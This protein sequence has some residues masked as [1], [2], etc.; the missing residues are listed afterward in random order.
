MF[1]HATRHSIVDLLESGVSPPE[2]ARQLDLAP[3]TVSYH[4]GRSQRD[5]ISAPSLDPVAPAVIRSKTR[6]AVASLLAEGLSRAEIARRL[7]LSKPAISYHVRRLGGTVDE[8]CARRYDWQA[9]QCYYELG[10]SVRECMRVFG[11]SSSSWTDADRRGDI[12]PRPSATPI[13]EFLVAGAY[14]GRNNLKLRLIK[15][16]LK[17]ASCECC[18][19]TEWRGLPITLALHHING[20]RL[21]NRLENL[22][23]LGPNC[24]SQ[25]DTY[26]GRNG[27][28][29]NVSP[30]GELLADRPI[31]AA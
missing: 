15:E 7:G 6:E 25:T 28:R 3:T 1:V 13:S 27:R 14:R 9:V 26:A 17:D 2:I 24:H 19:I 30:P 8:R 23:L 22:Q 18:G 16:G 12:L 31:A 5:D 29:L 4:I 21:D 11:F 10:H 20:E